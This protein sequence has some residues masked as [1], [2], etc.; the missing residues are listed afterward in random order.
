MTYISSLW[1]LTAVAVVTFTIVGRIRSSWRKLPPGPR[2]L[3]LIGNILQLRGKQWLTFTEL[4]KKYG[5]LMYFSIAGQP[6]VVINSLKVA[7]D[8][9]D[10]A[11]F[12]DRPRNIV[13]SDIMTGGMFVAFAH[14]GNA[15][16][17][18]RKAAHEGL[19][20]AIVNQYHPIQI[21]EAVLLTA[22][23]L[24]EPGRWV[25]HVRRT[26]ASSIMSIVYNRPPTSEQD[27]SIK[28][29]ND[30]TTRLTRAAMPGAHLV[31]SFPWMLRIPSKYAKWK[32]D[33]EGWY[34]K[35]SSMFESLFNSAKGEESPS[36]AATLAQAAGRHGLTEHENSWLAGTMYAAGAESSSAAMSWWMLA[37]VLY[38]DVQKRAQAELDMVVGRDRLPTFADYEYLPYVRAMVKETLR[39]RAVF[40]GLPRR[41]TEDDVYNG[42][43]I[44]AGSILIANVWHIN[45]NPENYGLD[46]EHFNPSRHLDETGQLASGL[47][48]T[49]EEN[50]VSFGFGRRICVGRHIANDTLFAVI[51]TLLWA[52]D[53]ER[54]T[55]EKGAPLPLDADGCIEDGVVIRPLPFEVKI[56]PRFSEAQAIVERG[57]ELLGHY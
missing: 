9:F 54:A 19:N 16:R 40:P 1:F 6:L 39:W 45:R 38:P 12:S 2:G 37:M 18:M 17:H 50:H 52:L 21:T 51:A 3:P 26:A 53:I 48:G 11:K 15:W 41:S 20:K 31:E 25:S 36:F 27:P 57:R 56:S 8:L 29:I 14:Y 28:K 10:R 24:A 44:P 4:G 49:K 7:T 42:Y 43:F 35:D 33:A 13:A 23:L 22:D 5:D 46:A 55:D 34:A 47:S 32:R 30:F